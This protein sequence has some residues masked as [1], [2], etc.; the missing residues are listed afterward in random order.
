[1][2]GVTGV[3]I[4]SIGVAHRTKPNKKLW[5]EGAVTEAEEVVTATIAEAHKIRM[6][7][8]IRSIAVIVEVPRPRSP[9]K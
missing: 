9:N 8:R 1:V 3:V 5:A 7:K 4:R 2:I 6:M